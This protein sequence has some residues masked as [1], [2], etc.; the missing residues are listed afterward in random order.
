M[1][2]ITA[3]K[4]LTFFEFFQ[5]YWL[6]VISIILLIIALSIKTYKYF[7]LKQEEKN[8]LISFSV[9]TDIVHYNTFLDRML[10]FLKL[11]PIIQQSIGCNIKYG[12]DYDKLQIRLFLI[13]ILFQ[14]LHK[15]IPNLT[16]EELLQL[17]QKL[18]QNLTRTN[19]SSML[20]NLLCS[21]NL[22]AVKIVYDK[23]QNTNSMSFLDIDNTL[24]LNFGQKACTNIDF[25]NYI[26]TLKNSSK[27]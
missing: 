27:K 1:K 10:F 9:N 13:S 11:K 17:S 16:S 8:L 23:L 21:P 18:Q 25:I 26:N 3:L 15:E 19:E 20:K 6:G 2:L 4:T 5:V 7:I 24:L 14:Q 22:S 12:S